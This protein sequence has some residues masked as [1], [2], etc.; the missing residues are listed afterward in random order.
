MFARTRLLA[1]ALALLTL[2][3]LAGCASQKCTPA[4]CADD[5]AIT[6]RIEAA[7]RANAAIASWDIRV[8]TINHTVYLY[9]IVDTNVQRSFIEETAHE[10]AG[11]EKVVNSISI[12]GRY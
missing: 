12:K 11:V 1:A 9:G 6:A 8:Q 10:A 4:N 5:A 7:L 2:L 3:S